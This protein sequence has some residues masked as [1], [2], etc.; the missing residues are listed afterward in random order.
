MKRSIEMRAQLIRDAGAGKFY[1][2]ARFDAIYNEA[3]LQ[4]REAVAEALR[5]HGIELPQPD[6]YAAA[7]AD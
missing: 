3:R 2:P 1:G 5:E 4:I 7:M 6:F